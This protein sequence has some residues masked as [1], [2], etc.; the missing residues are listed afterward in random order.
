MP[1]RS[2][3]SKKKKEINLE[4]VALYDVI[5]T[6]LVVTYD[7]DITLIHLSAVVFLVLVLLLTIVSSFMRE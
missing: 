4:L 5:K 7:N 2:F 1:L 6:Q 3:L